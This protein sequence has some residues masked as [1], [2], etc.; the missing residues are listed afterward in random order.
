MNDSI[1]TKFIRPTALTVTLIVFFVLMILDG[2]FHE[3]SVKAAYLTILESILT[4]QIIFYF[5]SRGAEKIASTMNKNEEQN[6]EEP[7]DIDL[8]QKEKD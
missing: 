5:S 6:L 2:N 1:F 4:V 8:N 3:F 7:I